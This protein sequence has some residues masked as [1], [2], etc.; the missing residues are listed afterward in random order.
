L[1]SKGLKGF[2]V[3]KAPRAHDSKGQRVSE[4][5]KV[6]RAPRLRGFRATL[7]L[8]RALKDLK[9]FKAVLVIL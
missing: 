8:F 7:F 6:S 1:G 5:L 9:T 3:L 4:A 2:R